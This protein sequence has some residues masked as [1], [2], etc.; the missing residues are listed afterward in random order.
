ME[1]IK[2]GLK[3]LALIVYKGIIMQIL[4]I[5]QRRGYINDCDLCILHNTCI[6]REIK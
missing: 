6:L 4:A 2:L 1:N 3:Y 5:H